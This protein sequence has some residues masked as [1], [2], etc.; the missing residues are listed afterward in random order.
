MIDPFSGDA[1]WVSPGSF[2]PPAHFY[3]QVL[4]AHIHPMVRHFMSLSND[5]IAARY[6]H[7]HP[8][9]KSEAVRGVLTHRPRHFLWGGADLMLVTNDDGHRG[10]VVVETNSSPSGQKSMPIASEDEERGGYRTLLERAFL[11]AL[12]RRG[13]PRTGVLAVFFD[14]NPM[15]AGGY[16]STLA[17]LTGEHVLLVS[18]PES[19]SESRVRVDQGG[20]IEARTPDEEWVK[21][22][23]ALRYVTQRPW[24]RLPVVTR[25]VLFNPILACLSGGRNKLLAAKAYDMSNAAL[26]E[27]G[28]AL[29]SPETIWD[30]TREEVPLWIERMGGYGVV[31]VPYANAGQGVYTI[32]SQVELDAFMALDHSYDRFI[33]Q[34]LVGHPHWS[35]RTSRGRLFHVGTVPNKRNEIF[36]ADIRVMVGAGPNGFFPVALYARRTRSPLQAELDESMDS[37]AMLGTNLSVKREDGSWGTEPERLL[38]MDSR[39]FNQLGLGLDDLVEAYLQTVMAVTS[40]DDM[41]Q[42]LVNTKG[43]FRRRLFAS[44]NPDPTLLAEVR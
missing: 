10:V 13:A 43:Q 20:F 7:L 36:V 28:L 8:R 15:E 39:N 32:A 11:P 42:R 26:N 14:K 30:V 19:A 23:G 4:N 44:L 12:G 25:T 1:E 34:G 22:R 41:A 35:S 38:I 16:A 33:V 3:P 21:V 40:I 17:D 29:H 18:L 31:K 37:W 6:G 2:E 27:R 5:R 9:A 24:T